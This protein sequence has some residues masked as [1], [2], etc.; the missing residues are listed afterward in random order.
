MQEVEIKCINKSDRQN[1]WERITHIWWE[2]YDWSEYWIRQEQAIDY[3]NSKEYSFYVN[4]WWD[5][6]NVIVSK[7]RFW[8]EYIKTENDWDE[9][10]NLLSL[11]KCTKYI[12]NLPIKKID[13]VRNKPKRLLISIKKKV[14][15]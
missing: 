14:D 1:P 9:P 11:N 3:I 7:S 4:V 2:N 15:F 5:R 10:N 6:V 8:N 12:L 13:S